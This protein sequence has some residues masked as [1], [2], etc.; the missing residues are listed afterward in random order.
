M[1]TVQLQQSLTEATN[2]FV[3]RCLPIS[4]SQFTLLDQGIDTNYTVRQQ[5][6][7]IDTSGLTQRGFCPDQTHPQHTDLSVGIWKTSL[8]A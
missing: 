6:G 1:A 5:Q 2:F 3:A 8:P 4:D 7:Y